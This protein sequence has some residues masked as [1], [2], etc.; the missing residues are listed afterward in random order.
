V[1]EAGIEPDRIRIQLLQNQNARCEMKVGVIGLGNMGSGMAANLLKGGH[2]V[3]VYNRTASKAQK[4]VEQGARYAGRVA[5]A[6]QGDVVIT[7]LAD[8]GAVESVCFGDLGVISNLRK[9][10]IHIAASTISVAL[11]ER[12]TA[13]HAA[14]GQRFV[15]APVF[16]RPDA[17]AAGKLFVAVSGPSE[18]V[19]ACMPLFEAI[20]QKT[21]RFGAKPA[22]AN[23]VK[24]SGNFLISSVIEAL[25]E[26]MA[27]VGKAGL[28]QHQYVDFLTST[29]FNAP[30]YKIY[31]ELI[32][33]KKFTPAGFA[34]PL[35]FKDNR[36]VLAA[37]E[38]LR[39]PLPL[40]SLIYNRFL[41]LL[42]HGGES[43]DWSAFSQ[44]AAEDA[45]QAAL[46]AGHA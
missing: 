26:A 5:D 2:E 8:D 29:L 42:A 30:V 13:A 21:F 41:T 27:L 46:P 39:V 25:A 6:C 15:S 22:D 18:T 10:G 38:T 23:L 7:M 33:D 16:G 28:D 14:A 43:L 34:A 40:A 4:L 31:G 9:G 32:A 20:G 12:L 36:L 1:Y 45:G 37:A 17:A 35:G 11:S 3:V 24:L 19:D 44:L